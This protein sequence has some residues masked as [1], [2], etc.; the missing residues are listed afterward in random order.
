MRAVPPKN[1]SEPALATYVAYSRKIN[2]L[3]HSRPGLFLTGT[4]GIS[5]LFILHN[6]P[7]DCGLPSC[8]VPSALNQGRAR[9][10]QRA[11]S[12]LACSVSCQG[13]FLDWISLRFLVLFRLCCTRAACTHDSPQLGVENT[14]AALWKHFIE[15]NLTP[16][17]IWILFFCNSKKVLLICIFSHFV[18]RRAYYIRLSYFLQ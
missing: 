7:Y 12:L 18:Q 13:F 14:I 15:N 9:F 17:T 10:S 11:G 4:R 8:F 2:Y 16:F 5:H 3:S 6:I 1:L